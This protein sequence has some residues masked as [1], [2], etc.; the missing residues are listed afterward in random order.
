MAPFRPFPPESE[1][2]QSLAEFDWIGAIRML[3]LSAR[4]ACPTCE[5][6]VITDVETDLGVPSLKYSTV[7]RRLMLWTLEATLRFIESR[8]F[9]RNT[10]VMDCDQLIYKDLSRW[11]Q[12][13]VDLGVIVRPNQKHKEEGG[14]PFLNTVMFL[15]GRSRKKLAAFFRKALE[16]AAAMPEPLLKWGAD[17]EAV[18]SLLEPI[19]S[20]IFER[21]GLTVKMID[22]EDV[23]ETISAGQIEA[24]ETTGQ[25]P[26]PTHAVLDGR[27]TR[28]PYLKP[29]FECTLMR[30]GQELVAAGA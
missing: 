24:L 17:Q 8:D 9:D 20:G 26:W 4:W 5:A 13:G 19:D 7:Q 1:L 16:I 6:H 3:L 10:V 14:F 28:K 30:L 12:N 29:A 21:S 18:R 11:F 15:N 23:I 25:M 22:S 2:H 27:W